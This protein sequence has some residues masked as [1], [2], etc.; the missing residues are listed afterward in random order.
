MPSFTMRSCASSLSCCAR[1]WSWTF[2]WWPVRRHST[3]LLSSS[4]A[5]LSPDSA[6]LSFALASCSSKAPHRSAKDLRTLS[7]K[8]SCSDLAARN[9]CC[10]SLVWCIRASCSLA[11]SSFTD[12]RTSLTE[13]L[14]APTSFRSSTISE[15]LLS[16]SCCSRVSSFRRKSCSAAWL[17][18]RSRASRASASRAAASCAE[19]NRR[20]TA[21]RS[22]TRSSLTAAKAALLRA[23]ASADSCA[24][25]SGVAGEGRAGAS[26][27]RDPLR[28]SSPSSRSSWVTASRAAHSSANL[29]STC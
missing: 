26:V 27:R 29:S 12:P 6:Q 4:T 23:E 15:P 28:T 9:C 24:W 17:A 16:C 5:A 7:C 22:A 13:I 10:T 25:S 11:I 21:L 18:S 2:S 14:S 1:I 3:S 19:E 8:P 20:S